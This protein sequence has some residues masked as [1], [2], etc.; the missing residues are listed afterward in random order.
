MPHAQCRLT[1][2]SFWRL[3][4]EGGWVGW[5][6]FGVIL[7]VFERGEPDRHPSVVSNQAFEGKEQINIEHESK[8]RLFRLQSGGPAVISGTNNPDLLQTEENWLACPISPPIRLFSGQTDC[9]HPIC[10]ARTVPEHVFR[11]RFV[12]FLG[13]QNLIFMRFCF[14]LI[15]QGI[16]RNP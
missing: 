9:A 10:G 11:P 3:F 14:G 1:V 15:R 4:G 8:T 2:G 5:V 6:S 7:A 16:S 13:D 12:F